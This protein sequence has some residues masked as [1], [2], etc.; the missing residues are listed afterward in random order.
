MKTFKE[1]RTSLDLH[2]NVKP[3]DILVKKMKDRYDPSKQYATIMHE[4]RSVLSALKKMVSPEAKKALAGAYMDGVDVVGPKYDNRS[5]AK[6]RLN[7]K[8]SG[9]AKELEKFVKDNVKPK[10]KKR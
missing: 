8:L 7:M 10:G 5:M 4:P 6:M 9:L 1:I 2:E 3:N